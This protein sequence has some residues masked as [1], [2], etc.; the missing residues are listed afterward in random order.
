MAS[1]V[2][3]V[4]DGGRGHH[5]HRRRPHRHHIRVWLAVGDVAVQMIPNGVIHMAFTLDAG[6]IENL[7]IELLDQNGK[8]MLVNPIPDSPPQWAQTNPAAET[9]TQAAD[10]MTASVTGNDAGGDD[11]I[12]LTVMVNGISFVATVDAKI[13][14]RVPVQTLTSV[15]IIA[16][17]A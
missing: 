2:I 7:A 3:N 11:V 9:L 16:T 14:P 12:Q 13:N 4:N 17:P 1:I 15:G 10:G 6:K 8:T 5:L